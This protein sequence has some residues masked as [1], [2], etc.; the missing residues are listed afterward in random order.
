M[1]TPKQMIAQM[2]ERCDKATPPRW[3]AVAIS[4]ILFQA[5]NG[6]ITTDKAWADAEFI[7]HA[8]TDLPAVLD[9]LEKAIERMEQISNA[10]VWT[11]EDKFDT[12]QGRPLLASY[13]ISTV[14]VAR[15]FLESAQDWAGGK[16]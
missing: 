7:A 14:D 9:L 10:P 4:S 11:L 1:T 2:R 13:G 3:D 16:K 8:R 6:A 12:H 15:S 5:A